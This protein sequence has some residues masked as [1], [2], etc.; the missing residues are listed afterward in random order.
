MISL[1][2]NVFIKM[3][4]VMI[5]HLR[6]LREQESREQCFSNVRPTLQKRSSMLKIMRECIKNK[7]RFDFDD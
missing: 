2:K 4:F 7:L 6:L 3:F 5:N 1:P